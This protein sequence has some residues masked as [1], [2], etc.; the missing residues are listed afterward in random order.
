MESGTTLWALAPRILPFAVVGLIFLTP[1]I[2][3]ALHDENPPHLFS[4]T[5]SK[6]IPILST[7]ITIFVFAEGTGFE[8]K[9]I[10]PR[11]GLNTINTQTDWPSYGNSPKGTRSVSYTHLTLPTILLV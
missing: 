11:S 9:E 7:A 2:R 10:S 8:V 4:S 3:N 1:W 5:L 6:A